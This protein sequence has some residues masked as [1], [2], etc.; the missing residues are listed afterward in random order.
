MNQEAVRALVAYESLFG[1]TRLVA[2]AIA[3]GL[4]EGGAQVACRSIREVE[5][6]EPGAFRLVVLG[7]PTHARTLPTPASRLEGERWLE[8]RMRG[9]RL[10]PRATE[11]GVREWIPRASLFGRRVAA[12]T[13]RADL[14]RLVSGSATHAIERLARSQGARVPVPGFEGRI[15]DRGA[16]LPGEEDRAR[17]WG[18]SLASHAVASVVTHA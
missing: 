16:L 3:E 7:A 12:F 15:D 2:E 5:A 9:H 8:H 14:P 13:T 6:A 17:A 11:S 1:A 4:F 10:E 18:R